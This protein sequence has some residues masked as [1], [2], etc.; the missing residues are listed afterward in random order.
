MMMLLVNKCA[1]GAWCLCSQLCDAVSWRL[2]LRDGH[3]WRTD[4]RLVSDVILYVL[5][6]YFSSP[7]SRAYIGLI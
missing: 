2:R 6:S 5:D 7:S 3:E 1:I 4:G